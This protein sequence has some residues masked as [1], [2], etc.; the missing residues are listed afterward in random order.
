MTPDA[1]GVVRVASLDVGDADA[2]R[3]LLAEVDATMPP[4]RGVVHLCSLD[5]RGAEQTTS[6]SL[7]EDVR[8][9]C[10]SL[11][12][13]VQALLRQETLDGAYPTTD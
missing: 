3:Q 11:L 12:A 10:G 13:L 2:L 4:L 7:A 1:E 9:G 6:Q 5:A 8:H